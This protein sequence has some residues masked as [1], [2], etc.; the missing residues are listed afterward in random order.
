MFTFKTQKELTGLAAIGA[1]TTIDIKIKKKECGYIAGGSWNSHDGYKINLMVKEDDNKSGFKWI[2]LSFQ[3]A[4]PEE[5]KEFL[6]KYYDKI[7]AKY[8]LRF[9]E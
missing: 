3:G 9:S 7:I 4:T 1:G 8:D 5:C 2:R 6:N